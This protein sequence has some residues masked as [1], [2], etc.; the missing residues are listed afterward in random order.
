MP[1]DFLTLSALE[2]R[3]NQFNDISGACLTSAHQMDKFENE[4]FRETFGRFFISSGLAD[5]TLSTSVRK[6]LFEAV[7][8]LRELLN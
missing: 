4:S 2:G 5:L 8:L 1:N 7:R 3:V 6:I